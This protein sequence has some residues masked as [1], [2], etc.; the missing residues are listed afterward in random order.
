MSEIRENRI[1]SSA[2]W[3]AYGDALGFMTE[4]ADEGRVAH[5][6]GQSK[7]TR[8]IPWRRKLG[9]KIGVFV[10]FPAGTYSDDTQLRLATSRAIRSDGSFDVAAFSK[11]ELPAWLNYSLGAGLATRE[12]AASL[13]RTSATWYSNFFDNKRANYIKAGG[14]GGAM[15][16]QPHVWAAR[17]LDDIPQILSNVIKN[18]ICTHGNP[19]AILGACFHALA[20][21]RALKAGR[22]LRIKELLDEVVE[23]KNIP[24]IIEN[25]ADLRLF[26][27]GQWLNRLD[28]SLDTVINNTVR[29][30]SDDL[31]L[32]QG[33][34]DVGVEAAYEEALKIL[35]GYSPDTRGSGTKTAILAAYL[36]SLFEHSGPEQAIIL[37]AN[38]LGSDTDSIATMAGAIL[39]AC[40]DAPLHHPLQDT[41]YISF[42]ATRLARIADRTGQRGFAYPDLRSW[43]PERAAVDSVVRTDEGL[44]LNGIARAEL[45]GRQQIP[46]SEGV[47]ISWLRLSFGQTILARIRDVPPYVDDIAKRVILNRPSQPQ[48]RQT[49]EPAMPDLFSKRSDKK[50]NDKETVSNDLSSKNLNDL[51][52]III[53][54]N[55]DPELI[56]N[57]LLSQARRDQND[58]VERGIALT[59]N[60]M[61]AFRA[62][63]R[64]GN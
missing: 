59:A 17:D 27:V 43:K 51:L 42:E 24:A 57:A 3:A 14:N 58:F 21:G 48:A 6:T 9:S 12:A 61:T 30:I 22:P 11:V 34:G 1:V 41:D 5:R 45:V 4:L 64:R 54:S 60:V 16:V 35:G 47:F 19:R 7:I 2:L 20:L 36:A 23:L 46:E 52:E 44:I 50:N 8:T 13:A 31:T 15:R 26:W 55:F 10:D 32:L 28:S 25:D 63:H 37:A 18:T 53:S 49:G 39:G 29:E 56:G 38:A 62:R 40:I 33:I